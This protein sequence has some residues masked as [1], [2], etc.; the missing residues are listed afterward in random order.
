MMKIYH[1][2]QFLL[3][4]LLSAGAT[5]CDYNDLPVNN[6]EIVLEILDDDGNAIEGVTQ[7]LPFGVNRSYTVRSSN[8]NYVKIT[9][10]K[11]WQSELIPSSRHFSITA[12]QFS[13]L[14]SEAAGE[15]VIDITH[16]DGRTLQTKITVAALEDDILL[17]MDPEEIE[18]TQFFA[19]G[20]TKEYA[21]TTQN[22]ASVDLAAPKG[23][24]VKE[25]LGNGLL[26]V[27]APMD[28]TEFDKTGTLTVTPRSLRGTA[29]TATT[30]GLEVST[31][32]P[33]MVFE[34][35]AYNCEFGKSLEIP[36]TVKNVSTTR[37]TALPAGWNA[38][39]KLAES[40]IVVTAPALDTQ[41][42]FAA[43]DMM[44]IL[45]GSKVGLE[46]TVS[47]NLGLGLST[48]EQVKALSTALRGGLLTVGENLK[49]GAVALMNDIDLTPMEGPI[50]IGDAAHSVAFPID[51]QNHKLTYAINGAQDLATNDM[52]GL[53]A[54]LEPGAAVS[55]LQ[56]D[57]TIITTQTTKSIVGA[58]AAINKGAAVKNVKA[59]VTFSC[60]ADISGKYDA[61]SVWG[62]LI[63]QSE[64]AAYSDILVTGS[65]ELTYMWRFGGIVGELTAFSEGSFTKC[66]NQ[67][68]IDMPFFMTAS[69]CEYGGI[70]AGNSL[71]SW[72]YTDLTNRGDITWSFL[73]AT[74]DNQTY[75]YA[76]G[77]ILGRGY[78]TLTNCNNY[79][80]IEGNDR[81]QNRRI[82][83]VV[84]GSGDGGAA[85]KQ[86]SLRMD[87]C[88]NYGEISTSSTLMGGV[89]GMAEK[90]ADNLIQN[91]TNEGAVSTS[92]SGKDVNTIA[93]FMGCA[94]DKNT[95]LNCVNKGSVSGL[96]RYRAA[97]LLGNVAGG[98]TV[99]I[100]NCR[101]EG[102]MNF[103]DTNTAKSFPLVAGLVILEK[104]NS[105]AII[106]N[107]AN[108]GSI[109]LTTASAYVIDPVY[110][111]QPPVDGKPDAQDTADCDQITKSNSEG[112]QIT[113]KEE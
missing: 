14:N 7:T 63:G 5:S 30:I 48:L 105:K 43:L 34:K 69:N 89:I 88:N 109:T 2:A 53:I 94:Y 27:T 3:L 35:T 17:T 73:N 18:G 91:C 10:P 33:V 106:R 42:S 45:L 99:T 77:G 80:K 81:Y 26:T 54:H 107:S 12:P 56:I 9:K 13:D 87:R 11:G 23:W 22:V 47:V 83:G 1:A 66:E 75:I 15:I 52:L 113:V 110:I 38:E 90:G 46:S 8:I 29:G 76:L 74:K 102:A 93:G 21:F 25:D 58:L 59:N 51:G 41:T 39:V 50:L 67:M 112:T 49:S 31:E 70:T 61:P 37:I 72:T 85:D 68:N 100:T 92:K 104:D 84:G 19:L 97:G 36:V 108:T 20:R 28:G 4:A 16:Q 82:G 6:G 98:G 103:K 101:N 24:T 79:G 86:Y 62:G 96:P 71:S 44:T 111:F 60:K 64:T 40:K 78:G 55:N 65:T 57:A 32:L 95:L